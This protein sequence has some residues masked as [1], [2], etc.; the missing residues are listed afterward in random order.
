MTARYQDIEAA[1]LALDVLESEALAL[2]EA[3][4]ERDPAFA[5]AVARWE[6]RLAK[7]AAA[8]PPAPPPPALFDRVLE[9]VRAETILGTVTVRAGEGE[10]REIAAGVAAKPLWRDPASGRQAMLVRMAAGATFTAHGHDLD[11]ECLVLEGKI[12]F[13]ALELQAGDFHLARQGFSHPAAVSETGCL[14]YVSGAL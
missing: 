5:A 1:E 8:A 11:E 13:G 7:L 14:L 6:Q 2:A 10:W 12:R 4:R 3:R 9:R